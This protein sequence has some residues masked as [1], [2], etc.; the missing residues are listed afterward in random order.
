MITDG[1]RAGVSDEA[2]RYLVLYFYETS[3]FGSQ[4]TRTRAHADY[5]VENVIE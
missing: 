5:K 2:H 3:V 1:R 4:C